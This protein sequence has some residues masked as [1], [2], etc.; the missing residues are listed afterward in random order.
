ILVLIALKRLSNHYNEAGI[1]NN[2]L[3][4]VIMAI[5]GGVVSVAVIIVAA[6]GLLSAL[7]IEIATWGDWTSFQQ[8]NWESLVT[9]S[10]LAPYIAAI[11]GSLVVLFVFVVVAAVFLR[12]SYTTLSAKTGVKMFST[13]GLLT[14]IGAVL[15]IIGVGLILLWVAQVLLAVA[16][17]S[18]KTQPAQPPESTPP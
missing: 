6:V 12:R 14:L 10:I 4:G 5:I 1:Y 2:A 11:L 18:I 17:F 3:Y 9:W 7:G 13:V 15:T 8:I 16:F